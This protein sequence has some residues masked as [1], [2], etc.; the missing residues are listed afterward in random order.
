[1]TDLERVALRHAKALG[2]AESALVAI[3]AMARHRSPSEAMLAEIGRIVADTEAD[4]ARIMKE[5]PEG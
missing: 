1:M 5:E 2:Y 3:G 4:I